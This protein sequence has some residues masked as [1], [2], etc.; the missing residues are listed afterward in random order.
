[1]RSSGTDQ[2]PRRP[3]NIAIKSSSVKAP[4]NFE[5]AIAALLCSVLIGWACTRG[6]IPATGERRFLGFTWEEEL[7]MGRQAAQEIAAVFGIYDDAQLDRFV[8]RVGRTVLSE[9]HLRAPGTAER[10]LEAP[11]S[12]QILDS[13]NINAMAIPGGHIYVT[14]GLLAHLNSVDQLAFVL[15]HEIGHITARHA[16]RRA[17]QQQFGQGLI[18]GGA[19]LG[20]VFGLPGGQILDLGGT[21]AQLIFLRHSREDELEA[22]RLAVRYTTIAGYDPR[23]SIGFFRTLSRIEEQEGA[24]LPNFLSTHPDPGNRLERIAELAAEWNTTRELKETDSAAYFAAIEGIVLGED[25]RNGFVR[26][27]V[28]YDPELRFRFPLPQGFRLINQPAQVVMIENQRRAIMGFIWTGE[29]S[30]QS[31]SANFHSQPV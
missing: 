23:E 13:P 20:Q 1:M 17:W 3:L 22:D 5:Q 21:A 15:A 9:S 19:I 29:S 28:F 14:R 26:R 6:I 4:F 2:P 30:L 18:L 16:A 8:E 27:Q 31:A 10:F 25:P 24:G 12:F 7:Q 11:I